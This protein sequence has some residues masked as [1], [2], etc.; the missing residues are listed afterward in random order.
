MTSRIQ[1]FEDKDNDR[2]IAV[3]FN[4]KGEVTNIDFFQGGF[5]ESTIQG[6]TEG[7]FNK[8]IFI[9]EIYNRLCSQFTKLT[10]EDRI[11]RACELYTIAFI[12]QEIN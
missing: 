7:I 12:F 8:N 10:F 1:I 6:A 5:D 3:L 4:K 2:T 11:Q 9:V